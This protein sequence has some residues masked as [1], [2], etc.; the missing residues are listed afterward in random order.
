MPR[1]RLLAFLLL[2]ILCLTSLSQ[3]PC[4]AQSENDDLAGVNVAIYGGSGVM[5]SS[6]RALEKMFEWMNASV[7]IITSLQIK[8]GSLDDYDILVV[9]GGS[10]STASSELDTEGRQIVKDFVKRGGSYFGICGGAT[11]GARHLGFFSGFMY[12]VNEPG[13][14]IHLTTMHINQTC[15]GPNLSAFPENFSTMYYA[16]QYFAPRIGF[17]VHTIATYDHNGGAGMV[18]FEYENGSV[19]LSSPHPE[20][21]EMNDRDDTDFGSDLDDPDSEWELLLEVSKW[22]IEASYVEPSD[23][24]P[25]SEPQNLNLPLIGVTSIGIVVVVI[26]GVLFYRKMNR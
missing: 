4:A 8:N 7:S 9:P 1:P 23:I 26:V 11:F 18:A 20:Y 17:A 16:S 2:T 24:T 15:N 19:F 21:E 5:F 12:A 14:T 10:E 6:R 13:S 22:L 25:T 3:N